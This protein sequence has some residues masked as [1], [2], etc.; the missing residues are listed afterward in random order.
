MGGSGPVGDVASGG[1]HL[2]SGYAWR[3]MWLERRRLMAVAGALLLFTAAL[4][5][6]RAM[7]PAGPVLFQAAKSQTAR[8]AAALPLGFVP[9]TG[10]VDTRAHYYARGDGYGFYFM[11][12]RAV[13]A[14]SNDK[15]TQVLN[16][17]FLGANANPKIEATRP[18]GTT[19]NE[20]GG[21]RARTNLQSYAR[22]TYRDL[23]PGVDMVFFGARG[24][25]NYEFHVE[26][27]AD[28][29]QIRL[30]YRGGRGVTIARNGNLVVHTNQGQLT[31]SRPV[32]YQGAG[33]QRHPG[34]SRS[35][36]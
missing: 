15:G 33:S 24:G 28:P 26:P 8:T 13:I 9:N 16:L 31:D 36:V 11:K 14:L 35:A 22:V 18:T 21:D 29:E 5:L 23:W 30:A 2:I 10:Q 12:T 32:S 1:V 34:S 3:S 20:L 17:S 19:V 25:F 27:G 6:S 7:L 4:V